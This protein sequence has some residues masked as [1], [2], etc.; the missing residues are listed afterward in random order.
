MKM[1]SNIQGGNAT[2]KV[3]CKYLSTSWKSW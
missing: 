1:S 3:F 2:K